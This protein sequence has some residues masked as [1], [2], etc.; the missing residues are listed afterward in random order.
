M[1]KWIPGGLWRSLS[2]R[3]WRAS[4]DQPSPLADALAGDSLALWN[5]ATHEE[6]P[7]IQKT[8]QP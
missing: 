5:P 6:A 8:F 4:L 2:I 3:A 7:L 1:M